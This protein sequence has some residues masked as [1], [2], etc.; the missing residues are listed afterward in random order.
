MFQF[1]SVVGDGA[2]TIFQKGQA[3]LHS[4]Y[5]LIGKEVSPLVFDFLRPFLSKGKHSEAGKGLLYI[6]NAEVIQF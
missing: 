4:L 6:G 3:D 2:H 5:D 1:L